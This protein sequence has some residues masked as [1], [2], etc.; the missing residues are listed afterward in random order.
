MALNRLC[1]IQAAL[2]KDLN[3]GEGI[4]LVDFLRKE[5]SR[6][7]PRI[8]EA[9]IPEAWLYWPSKLS[10]LG[11]HSLILK[12]GAEIAWKTDQ[13][14]V[15]DINLS[16]KFEPTTYLKQQIALDKYA[17]QR[18]K[19]WWILNMQPAQARMGQNV[20][21]S[22]VLNEEESWPPEARDKFFSA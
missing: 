14:P 8:Y 20:N 11:F 9:K 21:E 12:L 16:T 13:G 18:A 19:V 22:D 5:V 7:F 4:I 2:L 3:G 1:S 17:H 6:R 15:L 10:G